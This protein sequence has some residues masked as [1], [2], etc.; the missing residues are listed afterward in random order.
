MA[1]AL[2]EYLPKEKQNRCELAIE[3]LEEQC[4]IQSDEQDVVRDMHPNRLGN[5]FRNGRCIQ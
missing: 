1:F 2:R 3:C 4:P 5:M